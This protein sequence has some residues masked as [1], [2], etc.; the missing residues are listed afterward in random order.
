[1]THSSA[2][3]VSQ[4]VH[5]R[6]TILVW[7]V[8]ALLV[9]ALAWT[10][11]WLFA[12][13]QTVQALQ[14]WMLREKSF[15]RIWSCSHS[16]IGG[17]PT[18]IA[19]SCNA[20]RFEGLIFGHMYSGTLASFRATA[21]LSHPS[22]IDLQVGSPFVATSKDD[23]VGFQL[24][25]RGLGLRLGG[26]PDGLWRVSA[27]GQNLELHGG[28]GAV[29]F[30]ATAN[31]A[32]LVATQGAGA[33][34]DA[35][36]FD[37]S[38][39]GA[40][41][42]LIDQILGPGLPADI[43]AKGSVTKTDLDPRLTPAQNLARWQAAGGKVHLASLTLARGSTKFQARGSFAINA[44]HHI[45]GHFDT[46]SSGLE[47]VLQHYGIDPSLVSVGTFLSN[48]LSGHSSDA[49]PQKTAELRLPVDIEDGRLAVG[50]IR[51]TVQLPPVY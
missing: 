4:P 31:D 8:A 20:P 22:D 28:A 48:L 16:H 9:V 23:K 13:R 39:Q 33:E 19:I 14:A 24:G 21:D 51:T 35:L 42:P 45:D 10:A 18:G 44:A 26:S 27:T 5:G 46:K 15:G 12:A 29:A 32:T 37:I 50:P 47:P 7:L 30:N 49:S 2:G 25:W 36:D 41:L 34:G 38:L 40:S 3:E 1:M 6:R 43:A 11:L 17:Y